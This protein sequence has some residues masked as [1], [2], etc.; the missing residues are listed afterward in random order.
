MTELK[1]TINSSESLVRQPLSA[2][3]NWTGQWRAA[4]AL[5]FVLARR[6]IQAQYR[7]TLFGYVWALLPTLTA[8]ITFILLNQANLINTGEIPIP[9]PAYTLI[10]GF[11]WQL[12]SISVVTPIELTQS[13]KTLLAKLQFPRD[14]LIV[15]AVLLAMFDFAIKLILLPV[16]MISFGVWPD[17]GLVFFPVV[18]IITIVFGIS[19]GIALIPFNL[20]FNDVKFV[21]TL[22]LAFLVLI[23]PV[24]FVLP[25]QGVIGFLAKYNP[26]SILIETGRASLT[27]IPITDP[28]QLLLLGATSLVLV[29][30]S[31]SLYH[32]A[33]PIVVERQSS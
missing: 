10:G 17:S 19:I 12:F 6:N 30:A 27:E 9:Y 4:W 25:E 23:T 1:V 29:A 3:K 24:G 20:I 31:L 11:I 28:T 21:L 15:A 16:V 32:V 8:T 18:V 26:L 33:L 7:Q 13:L 5:G 22:L 14:S 2:V